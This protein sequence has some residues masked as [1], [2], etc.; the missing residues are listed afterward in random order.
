MCIKI[1]KNSNLYKCKFPN[2][3]NHSKFIHYSFPK[4][5]NNT[6]LRTIWFNT[7]IYCVFNFSRLFNQTGNAF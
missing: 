6:H 3:I 7:H 1:Y 5:Y 4:V 2:N